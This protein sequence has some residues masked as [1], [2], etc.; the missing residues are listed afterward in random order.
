[1]LKYM[2]NPVMVNGRELRI[3]L[4]VKVGTVWSECK[5]PNKKE[6]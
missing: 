5:D 6:K 1:M 3:P 4:D 2:D